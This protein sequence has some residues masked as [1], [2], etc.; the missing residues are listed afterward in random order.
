MLVTAETV[1][2]LKANASVA[3]K[4]QQSTV[5]SVMPQPSYVQ[6]S[7]ALKMNQSTSASI[8]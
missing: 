5:N 4:T 1:H 7:F 6:F 3:Y 2:D 8:S